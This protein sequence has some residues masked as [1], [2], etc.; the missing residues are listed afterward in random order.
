[1]FSGFLNSIKI[2]CNSSFIVSGID[3]ETKHGK[4]NILVIYS[5]I[6]GDDVLFVN[7]VSI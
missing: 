3:I 7:S 2:T 6:T 4:G 5:D 1:M